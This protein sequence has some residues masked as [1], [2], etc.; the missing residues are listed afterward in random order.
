MLTEQARSADLRM[1]STAFSMLTSLY[2]QLETRTVP[3]L[4]EAEQIRC[5]QYYYRLP[6]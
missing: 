4:S 2:Q 3:D 1:R 5:L 6:T